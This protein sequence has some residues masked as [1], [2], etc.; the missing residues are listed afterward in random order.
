MDT[1]DDLIKETLEHRAG[2]VG[3]ADIATNVTR[4]IRHHN[5]LK[6]AGSA[7]AV[8]VMA[9]AGIWGAGQIMKDDLPVS[10]ASTTTLDSGPCAGLSVIVGT[11]N[12]GPDDGTEPREPLN[13][14]T[15]EPG[16]NTIAMARTDYLWFQAS[17]PCRNKIVLVPQGPVLQGLAAGAGA[18]VPFSPTGEA[19]N[20]SLG[21]VSISTVHADTTHAA[22]EDLSLLLLRECDLSTCEPIAT[23]RV[24]ITDDPSNNGSTP[25]TKE[26]AP[27][28]P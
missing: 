1:L 6:V 17:G 19:S 7:A 23:L 22:T 18:A 16:L 27:P 2:Q 13:A 21:E 10:P 4:R 20:P 25:G 28:T 12:P 26:T 15:L 3:E 5:R 8:A 24:D 11:S 9:T 14:Q